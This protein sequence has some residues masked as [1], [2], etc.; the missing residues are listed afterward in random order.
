MVRER[1]FREKSVIILGFWLEKFFFLITI[2]ELKKEERKNLKIYGEE[3][4]INGLEFILLLLF[5]E[6]NENH[7]SIV[8]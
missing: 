4:R 1:K 5:L 3:W 6:N 8:A 7:L 2:R